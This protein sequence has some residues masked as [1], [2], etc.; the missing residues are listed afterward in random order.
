MSH[1]IA[2]SSVG[3]VIRGDSRKLKQD[4][5]SGVW[6]CGGWKLGGNYSTWNILIPHYWLSL[7]GHELKRCVNMARW[8]VIGITYAEYCVLDSEGE[9]IAEVF[10]LQDSTV[11]V[12]WFVSKFRSDCKMMLVFLL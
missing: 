2:T 9:A 3:G 7:A 8:R 10:C 12:P 5:W 6:G 1:A 11:L 4:A